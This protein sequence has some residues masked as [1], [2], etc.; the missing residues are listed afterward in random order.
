MQLGVLTARKPFKRVG[1]QDD[2]LVLLRVSMVLG[3][4]VVPLLHDHVG[5]MLWV[6]VSR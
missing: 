2:L 1:P 3:G 4:M 5:V 6:L